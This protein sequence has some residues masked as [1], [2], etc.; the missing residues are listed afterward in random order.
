MSELAAIPEPEPDTGAENISEGGALQLVSL[1]LDEHL[2][3]REAWRLALEAGTF[4]GGYSTAQRVVAA[5][6]AERAGREDTSSI[7]GR[8][9]ALL[10]AELSAL[11]HSKGPKDLDRLE[12]LA[13][14]LGQIER[15]SPKAKKK[16][17]DPAILGLLQGDTEG[18]EE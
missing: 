18:G 3:I 7:A 16:K 15:L 2:S 13:R 10:S 11:E 9:L 4:S 8:M 1:V 5:A 17:G 6:R 12:R 14:T